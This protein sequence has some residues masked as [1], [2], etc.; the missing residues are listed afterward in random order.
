MTQ[1][2]CVDCKGHTD[3]DTVM[4]E[5]NSKIIACVVCGYRKKLGIIPKDCDHP[6]AKY[7]SLGVFECGD[8]GRRYSDITRAVSQ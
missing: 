6:N 3:D 5:F 2:Y 8:C 1:S 4:N 7:L